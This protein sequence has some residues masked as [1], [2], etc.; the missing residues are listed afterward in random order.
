MHHVTPIPD[1]IESSA[2]ASILCAGVTVY[3]A[4]KYSETNPGDWVILPGA[5]GGL[6]HMALQYAKYM[7]KRVIAI[8]A[9]SH[10]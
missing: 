1:S 7:G 8:G 10:M 4:L 9:S 2:A 3:R 6:G 5:G